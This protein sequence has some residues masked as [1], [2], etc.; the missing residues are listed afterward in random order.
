MFRQGILL[1]LLAITSITGC[2]RSEVT[3][4][5]SPTENRDP[6]IG[7][8]LVPESEEISNYI[9]A[10]HDAFS[11][12]LCT[13][14][15]LTRNIAITAAHCIGLFKEDM[16]VFYGNTL[17]ALSGKFEIDKI[18]VSPYWEGSRENAKDTGDVALVHFIGKLPSNYR[19]AL[20]MNKPVSNGITLAVA[21]YGMIDSKSEDGVGILRKTELT[22][23]D[24]QF[25]DTEFLMDQSKGSGAC[26][27]DSG[28]PAFVYNNHRFYLIGITSRGEND[29]DNTC[30]V[31]GV[32]TNAYTYKTWIIRMIHKLSY[33]LTNPN[34]N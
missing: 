11:G 25:S 29:P 34:I 7:G 15:L 12:Q 9:V 21:G 8:T 16:Y 10:V 18:E 27:G 26:H 20:I 1:A 4:K 3:R 24:S 14:T 2:S 30:A 23:S 22:V 28:G 19:P 31:S 17:S 5:L 32:F 33:S 13:G 6:I